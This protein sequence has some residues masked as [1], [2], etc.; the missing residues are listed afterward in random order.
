MQ[1]L[2]EFW[3]TVVTYPLLYV[4]FLAALIVSG[5]GFVALSR[6]WARGRP[7]RRSDRLI[8]RVSGALLGVLA[9]TDIL[10]RAYG[11]TMHALIFWGSILLLVGSLFTHYVVPHTPRADA[12]D[13]IHLALDVAMLAG[14]VGL[15][16]ATVRRYVL[17]RLPTTVEDTL[18][19][20]L[21]AVLLLLTLAAEG[22]YVALA[23]PP[24]ADRA[25]LSQ[26]AGRLAETLPEATQR[27]C[28]PSCG[29]CCTS[30]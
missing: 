16:L 9:Q 11:G 14:F 8:R 7:A 15:A 6:R 4:L 30:G 18:T 10:R 21:L 27:S 23:D 20:I 26:A 24:W 3:H 2:R 22:T 29:R 13:V 25:L 28:T 1:L 5:A 12:N 19:L 17:R